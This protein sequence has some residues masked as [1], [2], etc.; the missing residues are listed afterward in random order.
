[1]RVAKHTIA[2]FF[3]SE[4]QSQLKTGLYI[5]VLKSVDLGFVEVHPKGVRFHKPLGLLL[6]KLST[7]DINDRTR[8]VAG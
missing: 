2:V 7:I 1:M 3:P 4:A 6:L 8:H 5:A